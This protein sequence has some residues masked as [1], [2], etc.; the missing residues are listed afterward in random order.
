MPEEEKK[1]I[2]KPIVRLFVC[3][4]IT[5]VGEL[6]IYVKST[7][8]AFNKA[9]EDAKEK[10]KGIFVANLVKDKDFSYAYLDRVSLV[11]E[12]EAK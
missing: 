2:V 9:S 10:A 7:E 1:D 12:E 11:Y 3:T 8:Q 6:P 5:N 4:I